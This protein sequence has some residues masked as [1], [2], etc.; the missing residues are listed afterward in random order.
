MA[1]AAPVS[2]QHTLL[3][4]EFMDIFLKTVVPPDKLL[5]TAQQEVAINSV[6]R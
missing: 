6:E 2:Q 1:C 4:L 5:G 3:L